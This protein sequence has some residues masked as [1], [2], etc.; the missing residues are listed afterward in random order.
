MSIPK[1]VSLL[2]KLIPLTVKKQLRSFKLLAM[3]FRQWESIKKGNFVDLSGNT[4]PWYTYPAIEYLSR[5]NFKDKAVFEW[6][7]GNSSVFWANRAGS[8]VSIESDKTWYDRIV[9]KKLSNQETHLAVEESVY[10]EAILKQESKYDIIVIDGQHRLECTKNAVKC[11][12]KSGMIIFDNSDWFP[13]SLRFLR[14]QGFIQIDFCGFG[15]GIHFTWA[16]S[17]FLGPEFDHD[18]FS[19]SKPLEPIGGFR[20]SCDD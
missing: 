3:D 20:Q 13:N 6:G 10:T 17:I 11:I 7:S 18:S 2:G 5:F 12:N 8:V 9:E 16:T 15:P 19:F 1:P 4:I 14:E